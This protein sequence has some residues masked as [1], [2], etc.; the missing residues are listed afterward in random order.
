[1]AFNSDSLSVDSVVTTTEDLDKICIAVGVDDLRRMLRLVAANAIN[2]QIQLNN[3]PTN[4]IVD[5]S[6]R[7]PID[8]AQSRIQAFFIDKAQ[9]KAAVFEAWASVQ[10]L[11]RVA[12]G[13]A[14]HS[15]QLWF[16]DTPIGASP[17]AVEIYLDR[18]DPQKDG[19]RIVGPLVPYGRKVYWNPTGRPR[20]TRKAGL[21]TKSAVFKVK[22]IQGI[23]KVVSNT[24]RRK[25]RGVVIAE[26][27][28]VTS[29]LPKDGKT[30]GLWI[31][32]RKKGAVGG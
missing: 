4:I 20:F 26:S 14:L 11:T 25:Y 8:T 27:W 24:L 7:K 28:V 5:N 17:A 22:K 10:R 32:F 31:G 1:M 23:M 19:F 18:M 15:Y 2:E 9:I 21:R 16:N 13:R 30:P 3:R 12:S 6:G 29:A